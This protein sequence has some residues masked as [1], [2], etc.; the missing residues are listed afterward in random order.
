VPDLIDALLQAARTDTSQRV[1]DVIAKYLGKDMPAP[2]P[3]S[4]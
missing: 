3:G 1:R 4:P 2:N